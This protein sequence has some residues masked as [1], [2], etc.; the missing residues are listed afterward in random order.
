MENN[1]VISFIIPVHNSEKFL[2]RCVESVVKEEKQPKDN[3]LAEVIIIENGSSDHTK[4]IGTALA[5]KYENVF[6]IC[7]EKGVSN[8][9]NAGVKAAH[10]EWIFFLD[11]D[12]YLPAGTL[13]KLLD[14]VNS[15][16]AADLYIFSYEKGNAIVNVATGEN[17]DGY[18]G[19]GVRECLAGMLRNP[20]RCMAVWGK[21][22]RHSII[23]QSSLDFNKKLSL[24]EDSDF[25]IR[26]IIKCG[27]IIFSQ[28]SC[29]HYSTDA[30]SAMRTYDGKKTEGYLLSLQTTQNAIPENDQQLYQAYQ[31]YILM[32][33]NI[34]MVR[35]VFSAGNRVAFSEKVKALKKL[36]REEIFQKAL[37]AVPVASCRSARMMPILLLKF[38]QYY[39]CGKVYELRAKQNEKKEMRTED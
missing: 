5:E 4:Q 16:K 1:I 29:Y 30:G 37:Q 17:A 35:E 22:F 33:L 25:L 11:A 20:T 8:A 26:Y 39:L 9:R 27:R 32:H 21:L 12:D 34:M 38:Q 36:L 10:G 23:Q 7:S 14:T 31:V 19:T 15:G 3:N 2:K 24:A 13:Q 18:E 28:E 6:L